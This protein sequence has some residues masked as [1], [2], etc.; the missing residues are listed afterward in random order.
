MD[1]ISSSYFIARGTDKAN[2]LFKRVRF[3]PLYSFPHH[4]EQNHKITRNTNRYFIHLDLDAFFAQVEQRDN[5]R[6][7]GKPVSVGGNGGMKG[8]CMTASYEARAYGVEIGMSVVEARKLCPN[9]I[10]VPCYGTKYEAILQN[11][12]HNVSKYVPDEFIE[13][14]SIDECFLEITNVV[15]NWFS[16]IKLAHKIKKMIRDIEHLTT[17][18]GLSYNKS[19]SK[20]AT[21]FDKPDGLSVVR[22]ENKDRIFKLPVSKIWGIGPRIER[23]MNL[24]G[25]FNIE[26]LANS[27]FHTIHKEFGINGVILRKIARGEDTS[28]IYLKKERLEQSFNHAHTLSEPIFEGHKIQNEIKRMVEYVCRK[29]RA[30]NFIATQV[31]F[32]IRYDDLGSVGDSVKMKPPTNDERDLLFYCRS[33]YK[34][35]QKPTQGR[36]ARQF[37]INVFDLHQVD[38]YNLDLFKPFQNLPFKELDYLKEKWGERIIRLGLDSQ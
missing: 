33:I 7:R 31:G 15:K 36:K 12:L 9:L 28:G 16:A 6:L 18:I 32:F 11:I 34:T 21:K 3:M 10:S 30:K 20:I 26:Q 2:S 27:N 29:M 25:I 23:R 37:G 5:P 19:Y 22:E 4:A 14:Y 24:L 8:I 35:F 13:Q 1:K 17:S 38:G